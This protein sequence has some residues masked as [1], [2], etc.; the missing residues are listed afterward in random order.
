MFMLYLSPNKHNW[1]LSMYNCIEQEYSNLVF[2][3][4]LA[5]FIWRKCGHMFKMSSHQIYVR[6]DAWLMDCYIYNSLAACLIMAQWHIALLS[7]V[8]MNGYTLKLWCF[9][10]FSVILNSPVIHQLQK[11]Q[12]KYVV[13]HV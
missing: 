3:T 5:G 7:G 12:H 1:L 8:L 6:H 4:P 10:N 13:I 11:L 2:F 9:N